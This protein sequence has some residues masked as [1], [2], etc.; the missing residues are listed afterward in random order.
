VRDFQ[1]LKDTLE[2]QSLKSMIV[3]AARTAPAL[4]VITD[5]LKKIC[6]G[7]RIVEADFLSHQ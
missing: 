6:P 2:A 7:K 4:L 5:A 3:L 1:I